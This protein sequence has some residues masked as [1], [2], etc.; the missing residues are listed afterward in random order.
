LLCC[1]GDLVEDVVVWLPSDIATGTDTNVSIR[2]R[3]G[4]SAAN[5]AVSAASTGAPVRFI[6]RVGSDAIGA[7]LVEDLVE[8]GVDTRVQREGHTGTIVVLVDPEGERSMLPDRAAASELGTVDRN[9]LDG[10]TWLH[11]PAY[12]LIVE[13]LATTTIRAIRTVQ[14]SGGTVSIDASSVAIV[15][16]VGVTRF[17][18]MLS[19]LGPDVVLCNRDEGIVLEVAAHNGLAGVDL[20]IVKAGPEEAVAYGD[21]EVLA[22][23]APPPLTNVRDTTGAGDAF[24]AGFILARM[25]SDDIT[26]AIQNGHR[27]AAKLLTRHSP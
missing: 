9:A 3:R 18:E 4:G 10:V 2:R 23:I 1:I 19:D 14:Q 22:T 16:E 6:G 17:G 12:S 8:N 15:Q 20:T 25:N 26:T 11:V 27:S 13:P 7:A 5:V 21:G 24:A